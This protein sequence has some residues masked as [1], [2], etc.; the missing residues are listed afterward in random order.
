M[1]SYQGEFPLVFAGSNA[2][3]KWES[4]GVYGFDGPIDFTNASV[5]APFG[6]LGMEEFETGEY[7]PAKCASTCYDLYDVDYETGDITDQCIFFN[8]YVLF[9]NGANPKFHC[10]YY[11][12]AFSKEQATNSGQLDGEDNLYAVGVSHGYY[13]QIAHFLPRN[14]YDSRDASSE[15]DV[16]T[17]TIHK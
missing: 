1:G 17:P 11:S 13:L 16:P 4:P 3:F 10:A 14:I 8:S 7:D 5:A 15:S 6:Y 12:H 9:K 2:Y